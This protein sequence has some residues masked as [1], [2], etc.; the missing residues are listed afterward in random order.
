MAPK[1][2]SLAPTVRTTSLTSKRRATA[3]SWSA[4]GGSPRCG[5]PPDA[6]RQMFTVF[7]PEQARLTFLSTSIG[8]L[9]IGAIAERSQ[10]F[11]AEAP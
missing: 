6:A 2:R 8:A 3:A 1:P 9:R 4:C 11:S 10:P 5:F 7:A